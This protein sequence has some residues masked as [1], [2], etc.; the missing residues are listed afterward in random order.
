MLIIIDTNLSRGGGGGLNVDSLKDLNQDLLAKWWWRFHEESNA[1]WV[2]VIRSIFGEGGGLMEGGD[3]VSKGSS[4]W[5]N[6][7]K[8]GREID[9]MG[10]QF[11]KSIEEVVGNAENIKFWEDSWL[12]D[13]SLKSRFGRLYQ[14]EV[15]KNI[16]IA[17][18]GEYVGDDWRWNLEWRREPRGREIGELEDL[19]SLLRGVLPKRGIVDRNVWR[20]DPTN[21]FSVK[22]LMS[23]IEEAR[24][25]GSVTRGSTIWLNVVP[26][27]ICIFVW[28]S[29]LRRIP[30]RV[31][32]AKKRINLHSVLCPRCGYEEETVDHALLN[33]TKVKSLWNNIIGRWWKLKCGECRSLEELWDVCNQWGSS[34]KGGKRWLATVWC[35]L[36]QIWSERNRLVFG[37][38]NNSLDEIFVTP[39]ISKLYISYSQRA[40]SD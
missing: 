22:S 28:H 37:Q 36:Y 4:V 8:V 35:I 17:E 18:K 9:D 25:R 19:Q 33:C 1:L 31:K 16:L 15:H 14:L 29:K 23:L 40:T 2:K 39:Q 7:V 3:G 27:K 5:S 21:G 13:E 38:L 6:I 11:S 12:I 30:V 32:L 20:L 34:E 24:G 10:I 26:K